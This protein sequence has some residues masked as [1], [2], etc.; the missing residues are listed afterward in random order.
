MRDTHEI[1]GTV[2]AAVLVILIGMAAAFCY[3]EDAI[4][5]PPVIEKPAEP[6]KPQWTA[7]G[8]FRTTAYCP[9]EKCCGRWAKNRPTDK[10][11]Q[12]IIY[13]ASGAIAEA[14]TTI[15]VD[16][17][18]IP[19]GSKVAINGHIY[20]AQDSGGA[21]EGNRIDIYH[22]DHET[23]KKYGVQDLDIFIKSN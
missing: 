12:P 13:T 9:C 8:T 14:G 21:I 6:S 15:A 11:G 20:I 19:Y 1:F 5:P 4:A 23:A 22:T 18:I 17:N 3:V 10:D 7:I 2:R 16:P